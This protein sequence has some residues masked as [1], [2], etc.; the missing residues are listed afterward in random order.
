MLY[1]IAILHFDVKNE[2]NSNNANQ[3][4]SNE[5]LC[6]TMT[7]PQDCIIMAKAYLKNGNKHTVILQ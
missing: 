3:L 6:L 5:P 1:T 4:T 7:T 2:S